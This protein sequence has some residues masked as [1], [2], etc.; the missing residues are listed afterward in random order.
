MFETKEAKSVTLSS[1]ANRVFRTL[2][3][4][5]ET[6]GIVP[7]HNYQRK[8]NTSYKC[9]SWLEYESQRL[10][11]RIRQAGTAGGKVRILNISC[12]AYTQHPEAFY[13]HM[14]CMW[15]ALS[16]PIWIVICNIHFTNIW[17]WARHRNNS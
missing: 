11:L 2:Y 5:E 16:F 13:S 12:D 6:M 14:G 15:H 17:P 3:L 8:M 7:Q 9:I 10:G 4:P 1:S